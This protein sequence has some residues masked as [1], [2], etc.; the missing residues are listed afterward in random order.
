[1]VPVDNVNDWLGEGDLLDGGHVEPV[2][3]LP[4]VDLVVLLEQAFQ[5]IV[6]SR[7]Y[8][9]VLTGFDSHPMP[10]HP[11]STLK[12]IIINR[13]ADTDS[14]GSVDPESGSG[15]RRTKITNKSR[16]KNMQFLVLKCWM[17][18]FES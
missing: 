17:F 6:S 10:A 8:V 9:F 4:P 18:S 5:S 3:V 14:I 15:S 7:V 1:L 11:P 12:E 16:I 2:H 13:V